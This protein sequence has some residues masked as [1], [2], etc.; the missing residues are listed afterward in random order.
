VKRASVA[1]I[2]VAVYV[3]SVLL[4]NWLTTRYGFVPVGFGEKA[5]AGTF[6]AGGA[7]V[8]RDAVQDAVGRAGVV[9][10]IVAAAVL[11]FAVAAPAVAVASGAAFL[12]SE[13]LDMV[14]Y[15]PLR[16]RARRF[17]DKRWAVAVAVAGALGAVADT[18]VFLRVAFGWSAV[19]PGMPGQLVGKGEVVAAL[20]VIGAVTSHA[21]LRESV[22]RAGA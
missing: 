20:I 2:A 3:A 18:V 14:A 12:V 13:T 8:V 5:T 4:A 16:A 15:S 19:W 11:S 6:A 21:V 10:L 22:D 1:I 17:G 9:A 7:L